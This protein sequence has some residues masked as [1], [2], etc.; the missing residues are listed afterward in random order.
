MIYKVLTYRH[1]GK[2][3]DLTTKK[4]YTHNQKWVSGSDRPA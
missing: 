2:L 1:N 4:T 3:R